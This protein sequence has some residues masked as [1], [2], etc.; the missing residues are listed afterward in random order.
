MEDTSHLPDGY[1]NPNRG[2]VAAADM[3]GQLSFGE[4]LEMS[5]ENMRE[6]HRQYPVL[7]AVP[8][9]TP[10]KLWGV[11]RWA[12][13]LAQ[14]LDATLVRRRASAHLSRE[15]S[16]FST[17]TPAKS[18]Q[19]MM[20]HYARQA[21][22]FGLDPIRLEQASIDQLERIARQGP[23]RFR[24]PQRRRLKKKINRMKGR[25]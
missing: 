4:V 6:R 23:P 7:D 17:H 20:Y 2:Q 9:T 22:L 24:P 10:P 12:Q 19:Q 5:A 1:H 11:P 8:P 21:K 15:A 14:F 13:Q 16:R 25:A 3:S 18:V